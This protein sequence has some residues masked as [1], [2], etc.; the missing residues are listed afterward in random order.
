MV[1]KTPQ[2]VS[3]NL[4]NPIKALR[5]LNRY[6]EFFPEFFKGFIGWQVQAIEAEKIKRIWLELTDGGKV[7]TVTLVPLLSSQECVSSL[8]S[9]VTTAR[10][11]SRPLCSLTPL[12]R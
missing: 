1:Y 10:E 5:V 6:L 4:I 8:L 3:C 9:E 12:Y 7:T 2:L 11:V